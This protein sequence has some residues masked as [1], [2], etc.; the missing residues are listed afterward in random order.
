MPRSQIDHIAI[1]APSLEMGAEYVKQKLGVSPQAGGEHPRMGTHNRLLKLGDRCYLE[2][3]AVNPEA[4]EPDRPRWF[5]LDRPDPFRPVRLAAWIARTDDIRAA[6]TA[7]PI[8][9]GEIEAMHRGRLHWL[10]TIPSDGSLPL[11]GIAPMLIQWP[12]AMHPAAMLPESGCALVR[13][14]GFHPEAGKVMRTLDAIG[15]E[16]D[17]QV[18]ELPPGRAP[19]LVA[20]IRTPAGLRQLSFPNGYERL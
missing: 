18:F 15:F 19:C 3:I 7:S 17:F 8:P 2:V 5:Q 16:G 4:P 10:I 13:L 9:L 14:K 12:D 20:H 1:T 6:A 11:Q